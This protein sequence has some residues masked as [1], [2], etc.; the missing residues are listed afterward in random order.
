MKIWKRKKITHLVQRQSEITNRLK[1]GWFLS[2]AWTIDKILTD[3][4]LLGRLLFPHMLHGGDNCT[5]PLEMKELCKIMHVS[6]FTHYNGMVW[7]SH[8]RFPLLLMRK[9]NKTK[10]ITKGKLVFLI[11]VLRVGF[12]ETVFKKIS[13]EM[14]V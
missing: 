9:M 10:R 14:A 1:K 2:W 3:S 5:Q 12:L 8:K 7:A 6:H 4:C 11:V 13:E